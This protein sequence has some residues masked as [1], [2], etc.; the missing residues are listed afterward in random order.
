M[1]EKSKLPELM[2]VNKNS[3]FEAMMIMMLLCNSVYKNKVGF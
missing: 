1:T 3:K 2:T